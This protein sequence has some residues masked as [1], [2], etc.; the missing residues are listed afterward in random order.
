M[1][2]T[3][4]RR[5]ELLAAYEDFLGKTDGVIITEYKGMSVAQISELRGKLRE[6]QGRYVIT[7]NT[8]FK[9]A[10]KE[11]GWPVP[12]DLLVG[13]TGV[14]LGNG[15]FPTVAKSIL[16]YAGD[17]AEIFAVKGGVFAG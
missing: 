3:K 7:K 6:V 14:V 1:A 2:I 9:L 11:T 12:E 15:N 16:A 8:L 17:H 13:T 10:M 4:A 5:A